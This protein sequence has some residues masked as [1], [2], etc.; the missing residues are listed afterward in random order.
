MT[1]YKPQSSQQFNKSIQTGL[2][3]G[4]VARSRA[5]F[6]FIDALTGKSKSKN[7]H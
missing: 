4:R 6:D 5:M 3:R 7:N 2:N 1:C